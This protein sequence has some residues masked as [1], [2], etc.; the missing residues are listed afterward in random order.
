MA[1]NRCFLHLIHQPMV[2]LRRQRLALYNGILCRSSFRHIFKR[3]EKNAKEE[4]H[5]CQTIINTNNMFDVL[6]RTMELV[7]LL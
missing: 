5:I 4:K 3:M 1:S 7:F 6:L 2:F